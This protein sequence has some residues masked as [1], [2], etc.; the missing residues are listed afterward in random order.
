MLAA[1][2]GE[3]QLCA[4]AV[5]VATEDVGTGGVTATGDEYLE[6][7][8]AAND[9]G[10]FEGSNAVELGRDDGTE[11]GDFAGVGDAVDVVVVEA[12][13]TP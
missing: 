6:A 3:D 11:G 2:A 8:A 12:G 7:I 9:G 10:S 13:A 1:N 5:F 4:A